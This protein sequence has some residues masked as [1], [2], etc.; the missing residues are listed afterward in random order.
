[1]SGLA[2][3]AGH[4]WPGS[5]FLSRF[6]EK[7]TQETNISWIQGKQV[8]ELGCGCAALPA[9]T[10]WLMGAKQIVA[11]DFNL[12]A[13][14]GL[15]TNLHKVKSRVIN[16]ERYS[17]MIKLPENKEGAPCSGT[18][19]TA[20]L[21]FG[22]KPTA[23]QFPLDDVDI[24]L[25]SYILYDPDSFIPLADTLFAICKIH[26]EQ[27]KRKS[28]SSSTKPSY[29]LL[30]LLTSHEPTREHVFLSALDTRGMKWRRD[31]YSLD[32][33]HVPGERKAQ[34]TSMLVVTMKQEAW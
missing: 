23:A 2:S 3:Y 15:E 11:T 4:I 12:E 13:L 14:T 31:E 26:A 6:M 25:G 30:I 10:A 21:A 7:L 33:A 8:V 27:Q 1:M 9:M 28:N 29:P 5:L 20:P 32:D 19:T 16:S 34:K 22:D 24:I 17:Q 18:F